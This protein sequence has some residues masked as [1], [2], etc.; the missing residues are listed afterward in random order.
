MTLGEMRADVRSRI[1]DPHRTKFEDIEIDQWLNSGALTIGRRLIPFIGE[2]WM[3]GRKNYA[4]ASSYTLFGN[5]YK[6]VR[7]DVDGIPAVEW[8]MQ[9]KGAFSTNQFHQG[10]ATAPYWYQDGYSLI[11]DPVATNEIDM[12]FIR[13]PAPMF[14]FYLG[15]ATGGSA[16][17]VADTNDTTTP[18]DYYNESEQMYCVIQMLSG[19]CMGQRAKV[20]DCVQSTGMTYHIHPDQ[21]FD[22]AV[23]SGDK[24]AVSDLCTLPDDYHELVVLEATIQAMRARP[25]QMEGRDP[26]AAIGV[27]QNELEAKFGTLTAAYGEQPG[28]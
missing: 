19:D 7:V 1:G 27:L 8:D 28:G 2:T 17:S 20:V 5:I 22:E 21:A 18:N 13:K 14:R 26:T 23:V 16:T 12:Y 10:A 25:M 6:I 24:Y 15:T 4:A 3:L 11:T 9:E